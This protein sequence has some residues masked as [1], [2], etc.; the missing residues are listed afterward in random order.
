MES[1]ATLLSNDLKRH[2]FNLFASWSGATAKPLGFPHAGFTGTSSNGTTNTAGTNSSNN[3]LGIIGTI[4]SGT[5]I[6]LGSISVEEEKLQ[7]SAL[8][9]SLKLNFVFFYICCLYQNLKENTCHE[10]I[11]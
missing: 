2:L 5:S 10:F 9:V 11:M 6:S 4:A 7:F 3:S 1:R 8:Q